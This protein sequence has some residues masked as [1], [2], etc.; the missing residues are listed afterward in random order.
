[1]SHQSHPQGSWGVHPLNSASQQPPPRQVTLRSRADRKQLDRF[2]LLQ[3]QTPAQSGPRTLQPGP[4]NGAGL[5]PGEDGAF[6]GKQTGF[7]PLFDASA[8]WWDSSLA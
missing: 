5:R 4:P 7:E 8:A 1:M 2:L 6:E 3:V